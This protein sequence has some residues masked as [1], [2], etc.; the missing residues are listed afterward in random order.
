MWIVQLALRRPLTFMALSLVIVLLGLF[1]LSRTAVDIFPSIRIPIAATIWFYTGLPPQEMANRIVLGTERNA[2][3]AITNVEH[4]ESQSLNGMAVV[5]AFFQPDVNEDLAYAQ[6][7]AVSQAQLRRC[8]PEPIPRSCWPT[9]PRPFRCCS[10]PFPARRSPR[11]K[12][13]TLR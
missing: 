11:P 1:T 2:Q 3:T 12:S 13:T 7:A 10:S 5:K 6:I 8:R 4:T 9:M